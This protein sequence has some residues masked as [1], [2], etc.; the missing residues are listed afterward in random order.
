MPAHKSL[1]KGSLRPGDYLANPYTYPR[2][3]YFPQLALPPVT[4][5]YRGI[6]GAN[7]RDRFGS[8]FESRAWP[9]AAPQLHRAIA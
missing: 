8:R 3:G 7:T 9:E 1:W 5:I 4:L 6:N 2:R